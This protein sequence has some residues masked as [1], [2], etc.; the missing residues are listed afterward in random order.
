MNGL[1]DLSRLL[2]RHL[3]SGNTALA[4]VSRHEFVYAGIVL[5]MRIIVNMGKPLLIVRAPN[6]RG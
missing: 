6:S 1:N 5:S 3:L 4:H 2:W